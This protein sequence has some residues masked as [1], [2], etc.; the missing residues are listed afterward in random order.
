MMIS[1]ARL[2]K[3]ISAACAS[4]T[5]KTTSS[6]MS[7]SFQVFLM[8]PVLYPDDVCNKQNEMNIWWIIFINKCFDYSLFSV[9]S[10]GTSDELTSR[11]SWYIQLMM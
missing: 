11:F 6:I 4:F 2:M 3:A 1:T 8:L 10:V 5:K 9:D 7:G